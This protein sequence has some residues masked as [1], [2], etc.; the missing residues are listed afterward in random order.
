ML[1]GP[2][3]MNV[4]HSQLWRAIRPAQR[5]LVSVAPGGAVKVWPEWLKAENTPSVRRLLMPAVKPPD[6]GHCWYAR[7]AFPNGVQALALNPN[8]AAESHDT[9]V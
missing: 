7:P 2:A 5:I 9:T 8:D 1:L 6:V 4:P 3:R